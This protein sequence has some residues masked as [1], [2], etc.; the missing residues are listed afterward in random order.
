MYLIGI[1]MWPLNS[2]F[3][4]CLSRLTSLREMRLVSGLPQVAVR[5]K[6]DSPVKHWQAASVK[7]LIINILGFMGHTASVMMM[8]L[9][10]CGTKVAIGSMSTMSLAVFP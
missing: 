4:L 8:K 7:D 10:E 2:G 1:M 9:S 3:P 5:F 6:H